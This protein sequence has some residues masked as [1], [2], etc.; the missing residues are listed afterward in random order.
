MKRK[1]EIRILI[2]NKKSL[3]KR[4]IKEIMDNS[5]FNK[6]I[7]SNFYKDA[8]TI[9]V[10]VSFNGEVETHRFIKYALKDGKNICIPKVLSKE[11]GMKAI[12]I[13]SFDE[14]KKGAYGILEPK[15]LTKKI[16]EKDIELILIPG[17]AFDK[18][19]GRIGY[20]GGFY[21]KF[22]KKVRKDTFKIALAYDFQILDEVPL[23]EHDVKIDGIITN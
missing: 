14:L 4:E 11:D 12:K 2:K 21:D 3:L 8:K 23:E 5:I 7:E 20:G 22:L 16:E 10:Y 18:N 19:G 9:L 6:I 17:V 13:D 1:K 15:N